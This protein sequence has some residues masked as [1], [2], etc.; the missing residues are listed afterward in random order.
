MRSRLL[1]ALG[2]AVALV[3]LGTVA[4]YAYDRAREDRIAE[5]IRVGGVRVGGL[6][7]DA[8]RARLQDSL[9]A[10]LDAPVVVRVAER[11]FELPSRQAGAVADLGGSV[12]EAIRRSREGNALTRAYRG[13]TGRDIEADLPLR[14]SY[15]AASVHQFV[16]GIE[17]KV[18][19]H[20]V[21]ARIELSGDGLRKV[22]GRDGLK[23]DTERLRARIEAAIL[24]PS[25]RDHSIRQKVRRDRP[26]ITVRKLARRN[27]TLITINRGA[28]R[29][30]LYKRLKLVRS[31]PIAVGQVGLET[32]AGRY[33][34]QNK[35]INPAWHVPDSDWA[36]KL[37]GTVVPPGP[38]NPIKARWLGIYNGAGIH[39][40]D[41]RSSIGTNASH[42][43]IRML[44]EHVT[45]LY[46]RVEVGTPV[47]IA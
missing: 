16:A 32:P 25:E 27:P 9:Q 35:A 28:F 37:R 34:V 2:L 47:Y 11:R 33:E 21:N 4:V 26:T 13:I 40:T 15:D 29:L 46:D 41:A 8:A 23:L 38:A 1:I 44:I 30:R 22:P 6:D 7:R 42:G 36:G 24:R 19:R 10:S 18:E 17:N 20:P 39:G 45:E 43:C 14:L 5:G 31:Y 12:D 3:L